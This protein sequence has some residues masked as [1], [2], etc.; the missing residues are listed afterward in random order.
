MP[1]PFSSRPT[2]HESTGDRPVLIL[3]SGAHRVDLAKVAPELGVDE[4][5]RLTGA[6]VLEVD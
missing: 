5:V 2:R 4:L 6:T 3:T 1:A